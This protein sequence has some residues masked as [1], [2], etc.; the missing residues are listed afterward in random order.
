MQFAP[1]IEIKKVWNIDINFTNTSPV[2]LI[3]DKRIDF[4]TYRGLAKND[5][6]TSTDMTSWF[7]KPFPFKDAGFF[8]GQI[9]CW[10]PDVNY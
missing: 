3:N 1:D 7:A 9:I 4:E 6:L 5:G 8:R 10:N 2:V